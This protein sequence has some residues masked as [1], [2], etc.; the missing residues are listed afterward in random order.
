MIYVWFYLKQV[1]TKEHK[2]GLDII[3]L[4]VLWRLM[5]ILVWSIYDCDVR[6]VVMMMVWSKDSDVCQ[7]LILTNVENCNEGLIQ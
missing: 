5:K 4:K 2:Y 3:D 6:F 7:D 1:C